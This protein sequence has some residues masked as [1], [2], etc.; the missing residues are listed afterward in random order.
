MRTAAP[1]M[2]L[3]QPVCKTRNK[4]KTKQ[5]P[6]GAIWEPLHPNRVFVRMNGHQALAQIDLQTIGGDLISLQFVYLYKL[7]VRQIEATTVATTSKGSKATVDK[8]SEV[9]LNWGAYEV[10]RM[11]YVAHLPGWHMILGKP[12]LQDVRQP[13]QRVLHQ[14]L[15][16]FLAWTDSL[17]VC[18]EEIK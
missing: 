7:L 12:I 18:G 14:L 3:Q 8:T 6:Q 11:F 16:S 2:Q 10:T 13:S 17:C 15:S 1:E 5:K 4:G 9:E